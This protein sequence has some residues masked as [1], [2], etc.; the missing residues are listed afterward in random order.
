MG[1]KLSSQFVDDESKTLLTSFNAHQNSSNPHPNWDGTVSGGFLGIGIPNF[2]TTIA[3]NDVTNGVNYVL[4]GLGTTPHLYKVTIR[5]VIADNG[6]TPGQ[7]VEWIN[8]YN[9]GT[10]W[11]QTPGVGADDTSIILVVHAVGNGVMITHPTTGTHLGINFN[12]WEFVV[13][14]WSGDAPKFLNGGG[15]ADFTH[16]ITAGTYGVAHEENVAHGFGAE[17]AKFEVVLKNVIAELGYSI[18]D[19]VV[20]LSSTSGNLQGTGASANATNVSWTAGNA[21]VS[22]THKTS[23]ASTGINFNNWDVILR[24]WSPGQNVASRFDFEIAEGTWPAQNTTTDYP[25]GLPGYPDVTQ[26]WLECVTAEHGWS[27]GDRV[28]PMTKAGLSANSKP[29]LH[30]NATDVFFVRDYQTVIPDNPIGD[31]E[32]PDP[33]KWKIIIKAYILP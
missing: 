14:V 29:M 7:E 6:Y 26:I 10:Y 24:A 1:D 25:H 22:I 5:N 15:D 3:A 16:T 20:P 31:F 21:G 23:G 33:A 2:T 19:E 17:P 32:V 11:S 9:P 12:N 30:T 8:A 18:G 27:P 4:H 13:R 28:I